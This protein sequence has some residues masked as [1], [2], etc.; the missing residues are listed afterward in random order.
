MSSPVL[1]I[2][3]D[4]EGNFH[5]PTESNG[6]ARNEHLDHLFSTFPKTRINSIGNVAQYCFAP[7]TR[8]SSIVTSVVWSALDWVFSSAT[9][10]LLSR[11]PRHALVMPPNHPR[12]F[13]QRPEATAT[14]RKVIQVATPLMVTNR[15]GSRHPKR[16]SLYGMIVDALG[17]VATCNGSRPS[18]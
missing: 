15:G 11:H 9:S 17:E 16:C 8:V 4:C 7:T 5:R 1:K 18:R 3:D 12:N 10:F 14:C 6:L 13:L 2:A